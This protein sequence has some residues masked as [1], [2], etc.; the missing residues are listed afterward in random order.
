M[1]NNGLDQSIQSVQDHWR[2]IRNTLDVVYYPSDWLD[3]TAQKRKQLFLLFACVQRP[4]YV[5]RISFIVC[6]EAIKI[7]SACSIEG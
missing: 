5:M 4:F 7:Q 3:Q 2:L 1:N 6:D